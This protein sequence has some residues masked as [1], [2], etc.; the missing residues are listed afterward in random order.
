M[1][2]GRWVHLFL[3]M[4][5]AVTLLAPLLAT[6]IAIALA[7]WGALS[8]LAVWRRPDLLRRPPAWCLDAA[9]ALGL[10]LAAG[11]WR[12]PLHLLAL[13][14]LAAPAATL[15]LPAA[16]TWGAVFT[17]A[18]AGVA[19]INGALDAVDASGGADQLATHLLL[20]VVTC[21]GVAFTADALRALAAERRRSER[22]AVEGERRRIAWELHDSAKQRLH[23]AALL[24]SH[25]A[26]TMGEGALQEVRGA[27]ADME[28]SIAELRSPLEG[29]PLDR[30]LRERA[31]ELAE[32][33][34]AAISVEGS[35]PPLP[36]TTATHVYRI[37]AEAMANAARHA[38]AA[39]IDVRLTA[40]DGALH[41]SVADDGTGLPDHPRPG[42]TGLLTMRSRAFAIGGR[43]TVE[44]GPGDR[45]TC[46]RLDLPLG[47]P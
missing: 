27:I 1:P 32:L 7:V 37:V 30:A 24:L 12:G 22:L 16:L 31:G 36:A 10:L 8:A 26:P 46:I 44:R 35:V 33:T 38:R 2:S 15:R 14:T 25:G 43:L 4:R 28:T 34:D 42:A 29:R 17:V 13:T 9:V 19:A 6:P 5:V 41:A 23:A 47:A 20:P 40:A 39:A 45:G 21:A 18:Y 3:A 11:D